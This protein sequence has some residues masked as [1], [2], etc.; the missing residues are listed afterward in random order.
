MANPVTS[1]QISENIESVS[2]PGVVQDSLRDINAKMPTQEELSTV[3]SKVATA[4]A[5][6][7]TGD[8]AFKA[9]EIKSGE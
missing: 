2:S 7:D 5:K 1:S 3:E 4:R 9:G 6:K 8:A